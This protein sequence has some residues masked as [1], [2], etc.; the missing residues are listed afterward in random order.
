MLKKIKE[1]LNQ[2]IHLVG[3]EKVTN[4]SRMQVAMNTILKQ[5]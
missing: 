5:H 2:N 3:V 1:I 4:M